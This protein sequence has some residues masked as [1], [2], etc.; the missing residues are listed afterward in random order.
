[1]VHEAG[2]AKAIMQGCNNDYFEYGEVLPIFL[3]YLG[4]KAIESKDAYELFLMN[5]L[6]AVKKDALQFLSDKKA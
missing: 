3:E 5:R 6:N 2:H 4:C 1:M